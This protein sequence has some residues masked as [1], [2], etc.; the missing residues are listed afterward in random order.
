MPALTPQQALENFR[1]FTEIH[2][3]RNSP[4]AYAASVREIADVVLQQGIQGDDNHPTPTHSQLIDH[5]RNCLQFIDSVFPPDPGE[6][7]AVTITHS[8]DD[9]PEATINL[10]PIRRILAF[11]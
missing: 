11:A 3:T 10:L 8:A 4:E 2:P 6:S 9:G 1:L 5:L 7:P